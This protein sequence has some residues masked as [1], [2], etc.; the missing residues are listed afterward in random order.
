MRLQHQASLAEKDSQIQAMMYKFK[1]NPQIDEFIKEA[2]SL[3]SLLM[4]QEEILCQKISQINPYWKTS[5]KLTNQVIYMRIEYKEI[6]KMFSKFIT[7]QES[8]DGR[9]A[10]LPK[11]EVSH[12]DILFMD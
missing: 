6:H 8:E 9:M 4:Q 10:D 1:D 11:L 3:N 5:D 7:W 2:V 12:K